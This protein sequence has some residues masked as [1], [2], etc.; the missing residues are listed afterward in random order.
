MTVDNYKIGFT[1]EMQIRK[2]KPEHKR[3]WVAAVQQGVV[4][5]FSDEDFIITDGWTSKNVIPTLAQN[6]IL[7]AAFAATTQVSTWYVGL[8]STAYTALIS[9]TFSGFLTAAT[10]V[11]AYTGNPNRLAYVPNTISGGVFT[12]SS[13]PTT[14]TFTS[15]VT[16][17]GGFIT[18]TLAQGN[19]TGYLISAVRTPTAKSLDVAEQLVVTAGVSLT[20]V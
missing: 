17:N 19:S 3:A 1:Y 8:H 20:S 9:D 14:F 10:E 16:I 2:I 11:T 12:N 5:E 13:A 15:P 6:Y 18:S 7:G 4:N